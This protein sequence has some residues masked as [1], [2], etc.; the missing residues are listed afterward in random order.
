MFQDVLHKWNMISRPC[1]WFKSRPQSTDKKVEIDGKPP[2]LHNHYKTQRSSNSTHMY[3]TQISFIV[4]NT[5]KMWLSQFFKVIT[6]AT[7][8]DVTLQSSSSASLSSLSS[9][10][11]CESMDLLSWT[12]YSYA[13]PFSGYSSKT[14]APVTIVSSVLGS[15]RSY[16]TFNYPGVYFRQQSS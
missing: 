12:C 11:E 7:P 16:R 14:M 10:S 8:C 6:L 1:F 2:W 3:V 9:T 4:Q 15:M 5:L 13:W